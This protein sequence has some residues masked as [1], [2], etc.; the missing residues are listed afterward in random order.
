MDFAWF[1]L[2]PHSLSGGI[3]VG[4]NTETLRVNKVD[5]GDLCV[6][7]HMKCRNDSF[8]WILVPV[9]GEAQ[10]NLKHEFLAYLVGVCENETLPFLVGGDFNILRRREDKNNDNFNPCCSFIFNAI[11]ESLNLRDIA[12]SGRNFTWENRRHT[13]I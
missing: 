5:L 9:Y 13:Y 11:I 8:Q 6:K 3:L 7:N 2:P 1:F 10:D 12:L 4:I